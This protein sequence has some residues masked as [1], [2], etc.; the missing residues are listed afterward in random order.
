MYLYNLL[1]WPNLVTG[2][3]KPSLIIFIF[4]GYTTSSDSSAIISDLEVKFYSCDSCKLSY[5]VQC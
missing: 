2:L 5:L 4:I 1:A 3:A